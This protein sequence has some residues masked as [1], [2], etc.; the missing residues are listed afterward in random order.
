MP[1]NKNAMTRYMLLDKLLSDRYHNYSITDMVEYI[2][3]RLPE[4]S[5]ESG[6]IVRRTVEKDIVYLEYGPFAV[7]IERYKVDAFSETTQKTYTKHCLRYEDSTFSIFREKL[8]DDEKLMLREALRLVGQFDGLPEFAALEKL[9]LGLGVGDDA[10]KVISFQKNPIGE[11]NLLGTLFTAIS[12]QIVVEIEYRRFNVDGTPRNIKM[13]PYLLKEYNC[14]WYLLGAIVGQEDIYTL[15][16]D[17]MLGLHFLPEYEYVP[18]AGDIGERFEDIIGM[19]YIEKAPVQTIVFWVSDAEV[20]YVETKP[21]HESQTK[22]STEKSDELRRRYRKLV[23][24]KFYQI[25]C[26]NNYELCRELLSFGEN[27]IVL[28]P[29][30]LKDTLRA[31]IKALEKA[32]YRVRK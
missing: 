24:G 1:A 21:L 15:A 31:R 23:G 13:H 3:K 32:Y 19:T 17:R 22:L 26:K 10:S 16:L 28:E 8:N 4:I 11:T 12:R 27:L 29:E 7:D 5:P 25:M 20:G 2:N 14:R 18:Y 6:S 9:R 30:S